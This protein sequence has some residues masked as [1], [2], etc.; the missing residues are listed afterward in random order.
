MANPLRA[1]RDLINA[2]VLKGKVG[3]VERGDCMFVDKARHLQ[4]AGAVA[5]IVMGE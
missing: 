4:R 3:I 5:G 1:C 2:D